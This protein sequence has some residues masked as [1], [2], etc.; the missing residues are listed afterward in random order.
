[1]KYKLPDKVTE[2]MDKIRNEGYEIYAVGGCVRNM[3]LKIKTKDWDFTTNATPLQIVK[4]FPNSFY[5]NKFGTVGIPIKEK[6]KGKDQTAVFEI[7]T[8]RSE[9]GYSDNRHPDNI[10]WGNRLEEDLKRRDFTIN[11][12]AFD[13]KNLIDP[14]KGQIDLA[15]KLIKAVGD[16]NERFK[17]DALRMMRAVRIASQ[18]N[19]LIDEKTYKAISINS[20]LLQKVS[21][22]RIRD[23]LVKILSANYPA[24]GIRMLKNFSILSIILP[25]LEKCFGIEQKSPKRHHKY[26]VG[27][28]LLLSLEKCPCANPIVRFATLLHDVGKAVTYKKTAEGVITFYNHEIFSA[29]IVKNISNRLRFAKHD[30]DKLLCLVRYHQFTVNENQTDSALRRFIKNVG[31][32]NLQDILSLGTG[33]RLGG[34]ARES[35]WRLELYKKRLI[36]VQKQPFRVQ[37]LKVS[38]HDVMEIYGIGPG[39]YV[40]SVLNMLFSDVIEGKLKNVH[41]MLIQRIKDLK[42]ESKSLWPKSPELH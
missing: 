5:D 20:I 33:D 31:P 21:G 7:T 19:F 18:L 16:P 15:N 10:K 27:T 4:I 32:E 9:S 6:V 25:E 22:E 2:V 1:M 3:I 8:F 34:G 37:D 12:I 26:D 35:S 14:Y 40:G 38:G 39:P 11:S 36:E 13:G 29:S 17:E 30:R 28:H 42:K 24:D 41:K 23:E